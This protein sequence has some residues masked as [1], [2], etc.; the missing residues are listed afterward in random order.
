MIISSAY[1]Q[2]LDAE[3]AHLRAQGYVIVDKPYRI[4]ELLAA[5]HALLRGEQ[6]RA[7]GA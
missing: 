1:R 5:V 6:A 4:E 2:L 3:A 7:V